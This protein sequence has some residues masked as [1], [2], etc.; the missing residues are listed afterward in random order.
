M[1]KHT[2]RP[3]IAIGLIT[4]CLTLFVSAR[5]LPAPSSCLIP[6]VAQGFAQAKAV[7]IGE[8]EEIIPPR[9]DSADGE[10]FDRAHL[11]KFKVERSWKGGMFGPVT[12][13]ALQGDKIFALPPIRKGERYLVYADAVDVNEAPTDQLM[14]S[15]CNRTALLPLNAKPQKRIM[16]PAVNRENGTN[17]IAALDSLLFLKRR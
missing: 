9:S 16:E 17:D 2:R 7:F 8:V 13:W 3:D 5:A 1:T 14:L 12:A 15:A 11:I 6:E 4:V 10:F